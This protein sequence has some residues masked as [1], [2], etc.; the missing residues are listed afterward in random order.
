MESTSSTSI[1]H[2]A[3]QS[4]FKRGMALSHYDYAYESLM[5]SY[6]VSDGALPT[7]KFSVAIRKLHV[8]VVPEQLP[9]RTEERTEIEAFIR[10]AIVTGSTGKPL[11]ISGM[12]GKQLVRTFNAHTGS[13]LH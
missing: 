4:Y 13:K 12:P 3:H 2:V 11:Y 9:C 7:D 10:D 5:D 6:D 8:S 1:Q